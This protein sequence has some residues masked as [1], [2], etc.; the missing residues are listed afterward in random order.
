MG[1]SS[2]NGWKKRG[3]PVFP[4]GPHLIVAFTSAYALLRPDDNHHSEDQD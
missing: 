1:K 3:F 2:K 4:I